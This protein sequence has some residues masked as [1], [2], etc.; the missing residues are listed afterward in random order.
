MK[1]Y[2]RQILL[3]EVGIEGQR[4]LQNSRVLIIGAGGLGTPAAQYLAAAGVGTLT[5][6]D[7]DLVHESNLHRQV[8]FRSQDIGKNKAEVLAEQLREQ[9]K[10]I[11]VES[12]PAYLD[13]KR[14]LEHFPDSALIVDGTDNFESRFLI[15][16]VACLFDKPVVFA[17]ISQF[18]GQLSVFW[19]SQ[20]PCYRCLLPEPPKAKIGNCA[21]A[22]VLGPVPGIL[23]TMLAME[24]IKV[25]LGQRGGAAL[26]P[27]IGQ[28]QIF[29]FA[30]NEQ[31]TLRLRRRSRCRCEEKDLSVESIDEISLGSGKLC[32]AVNSFDVLID[33]RTLEEWNDFHLEGSLHWPL[34]QFEEHK[35]PPLNPEKKYALICLS[36]V[37][38]KCA[39]E[40]LAQLGYSNVEVISKSVYDV[41]KE[42]ILHEQP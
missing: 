12:I 33:V 27:L 36:G 28:V 5:I 17:A 3:P 32:Q 23:G 31:R 16:D 2:Q 30:T 34:R 21:E 29:N 35:L 4:V 11:N 24:A 7:G 26:Q 18:E 19:K 20:G 42:R 39:Q 38:A 41:E 37:R 8:L 1:R 25:L 22:G 6:I 10:E 14:A 40:I 15:N 13:K 9:N